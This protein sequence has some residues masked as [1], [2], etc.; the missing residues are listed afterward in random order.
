[1]TAV[2]FSR[3]GKTLAT[4]SFDHSVRLWE[5]GS[6]RHSKLVGFKEYSA[7]AITPDGKLLAFVEQW[8]STVRL[9][10]VASRCER[11]TL[12]QPVHVWSVAFSPD[13]KLL[14]VGCSDGIV[15][16]WDIDAGREVD[17]FVGHEEPV[18]SVVFSPDGRTLASGGIDMTVRLWDV[19]ARRPLAT[20]RGHTA[21]VSSVVFSPDGKALASASD[22]TTVRLW[23]TAT[24]K[25]LKTLGGQRTALNSAAF[26][27][28]GK[29]LATG[30][31]DGTIRVWDVATGEAAT[32]LRGHTAP[33]TALAYTPDGRSLVS[34]GGDGAVKVW[35]VA[36]RLDPNILTGHKGWLSSL[37]FS[38][39]G[40]TLAVADVLDNTVKLWD[41][42]TRQQV[43]LRGHKNPV[44]CVAF[45]PDGQ[46]L[47]SGGVLELDGG[48]VRLWDVPG[49]KLA[50]RFQLEHD[51]YVSSVAFS[52]D[53]KLLLAGETGGRVAVWDLTSKQKT[54]VKDLNGTGLHFSPNGRLLAASLGN[55]VRLWDVATWQ[56]VAEL[57]GDNA[58]VIGLAFAPDGKTLA[59]GD[60]VG[61]LRL[62]DVAQKR[63]VASR[64][65]HASETSIGRAHSGP[66]LAFSPDGRRLATSG[67]G[68]AVKLWAVAPRTESI[69]FHGDVTLLQEVANFTGHGGPVTCVAFSPDGNTLASASTDATIRLWQAPPL[70]AVLPEPA[71][72]RSLPP[73]ETI[74]L[75]T[76]HL[77]D[78]ARATLT[79]EGNGHRIDVTAVDGTDDHVRLAQAFDNLQEGATYT[80]RFRAKANAPREIG[81]YAQRNG[82]PDSDCIG[83]DEAVP[84]TDQWKNYEVQFQANGLAAEN[85]L[86]FNVGQRTGTVWIDDFTVTKG[87]NAQKGLGWARSRVQSGIRAF[88]GGRL[89]DAIRDLQAAS[90]LLRT[91]LKVNPNDGR[92]SSNLGISLGF[93]GSAQR[94]CKRPV[95][96]LAAFQEARSVLESMRNPAPIDLYNLACDYAQ[97]SVLLQHA[98]T[99]PTAAERESLANQAVDALRRSLGA[100]M[101]DFALIDRDH[102]LDP[103][104]ERP[105][106]R[107]LIKAA[108]AK[109]KSDAP[110]PP[111]GKNDK[112]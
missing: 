90:D 82:V 21:Y 58:A 76:L 5:V 100:G 30:A 60:A 101:K 109:T 110:P 46:T 106:F 7:V 51:I 50:T 6:Q 95:E 97:L 63:E 68:S 108:N 40:K 96:A 12:T 69:P 103:L 14:A 59:T 22:D 23:D 20:L 78:T 18:P 25:P 83:L 1:V 19:A 66:S 41:L 37:A 72:A 53:G 93:I 89:P 112:K 107:A 34:G 77:Q 49:Q 38:P 92:L 8:S 42:A 87:G 11:A 10:D 102:D 44:W 105:D 99:P 71:E 13:G 74:P 67:P 15:R 84:L 2:A 17:R 3:D 43:V 35:D 48:G 57:K 32:L 31:A 94:D 75:F 79:P 47:A 45:S 55:A 61:T 98:A 86:V 54:G 29:A 39:D 64:R 88:E 65:T 80:V 16:L 56:P 33:I 27:P 111:K 28:D 4:S 85:L 73:A 36:T 104:R 24:R 26:S 70:S 91:L 81:I 62:W 52:P 9:W